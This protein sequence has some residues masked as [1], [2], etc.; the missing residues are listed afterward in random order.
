[1]AEG[2]GTVRSEGVV[3][4]DLSM[5]EGKAEFF[6]RHVGR[7]RDRPFTLA[8][9]TALARLETLWAVE[10]GMKVIEPGCG[11]GRLTA[12]L[13]GSVGPGGRIMAFDPSGKMMEAHRSLVSSP[14]VDGRVA[15]A[16]EVELPQ[17]WADRVICF[18]VFPHFDDK[19]KALTNL[20]SAMKPE[21]R[22]FVAHL[23]SREELAL[24]HAEAGQVVK[25]D[26]IPPD[27]QMSA[28]F[29]QAGM[30]VDEIADE[31]GHYHL[32]AHLA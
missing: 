2:R 8:E 26:K 28:L 9:Q 6:D 13:V 24:L 31:P 21:G 27:E 11:A 22:L 18:R 4:A 3:R 1:M 29:T 7:F 23:H 30:V 12:R 20:A 17:Q 10:P 15:T 19:L 32:A 5:A 25:E 14:R 16:E